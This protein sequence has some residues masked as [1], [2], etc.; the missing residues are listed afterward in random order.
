M[1]KQFESE[2][3]RVAPF[4]TE[5]QAEIIRK[6][7]ETV[8]FKYA[9]MFAITFSAVA[10]LLVAIVVGSG[11]LK[12]GPDSTSVP[13]IEEVREQYKSL[14]SVAIVDKYSVDGKSWEANFEIHKFLKETWNVLDW[15]LNEKVELGYDNDYKIGMIAR[16]DLDLP[17]E[18][19]WFYL[20]YEGDGFLIDGDFGVAELRGYKAETLASILG[21]DYENRHVG[22]EDNAVISDDFDIVYYSLFDKHRVTANDK[23][24]KW[25]RLFDAIEWYPHLEIERIQGPNQA[26]TLAIIEQGDK[27]VMRKQVQ[28]YINEDKQLIEIGGELGNGQVKK[29]DYDEWMA[30]INAEAEDLFSIRY[31]R[32]KKEERFFEE[33]LAQMDGQDYHYVNGASFS[34][35]H[36]LK[37]GNDIYYFSYGGDTGEALLVKQTKLNF[38]YRTPGGYKVTDQLMEMTV[39]DMNALLDELKWASGSVNAESPASG[40][41]TWDET[42]KVWVL[43]QDEIETMWIERS[44]THKHRWA[45]LDVE[46]TQK[47]KLYLQELRVK[48][49]E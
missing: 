44:D 49:N 3:E 30:A 29:E 23:I 34:P 36:S 43:H 37:I 33:M 40:E 26:L 41:F 22:T 47:M 24:Q 4:R 9:P 18:E 28:L 13:L 6:S 12:S 1:K 31:P 8:K 48:L 17:T 14:T 10:A 45:E 20:W 15:N 32:D 35:R 5:L 38:A 7:S 46:Q 25:Q 11:V 2:I 42:Y 21:M 39:N 27:R 16:R 19:L